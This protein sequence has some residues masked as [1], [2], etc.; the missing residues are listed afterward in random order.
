MNWPS[1]RAINLLEEWR[2]GR[3]FLL[4]LLES[5]DGRFDLKIGGFVKDSSLS[6]L[7]L[8]LENSG[9]FRLRLDDVTFTYLDA[10]DAPVDMR[11]GKEAFLILCLTRRG[12]C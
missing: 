8:D 4:V 12:S 9:E 10:G 7:V 2:K 1:D 11:E 6:E 5:A 3:D